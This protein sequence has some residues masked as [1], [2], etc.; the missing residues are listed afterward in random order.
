MLT[1]SWNCKGCDF[2]SSK[3]WQW[4]NPLQLAAVQETFKTDPKLTVP[5]F[6]TFTAPASRLPLS[7]GSSSDA[8]ATTRGR[9]KGSLASFIATNV[10][11]FYD[12][13]RVDAA[14]TNVELLV[15]SLVRKSTAPPESSAPFAFLF[16]NCYVRP[17]PD[18]VDFDDLFA[19]FDALR[20]Q[21]DCPVIIAGDFNAHL[22][23]P[24]AQRLPS[25][26]DVCF[27]D[28]V[29]RLESVG[30]SYAFY[31]SRE[32]LTIQCRCPRLQSLAIARCRVFYSGLFLNQCNFILACPN[33]VISRVKCLPIFSHVLW[34]MV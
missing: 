26:R 4:V 2:R 25:P 3:F 12:V 28:F 11:A 32:C 14:V 5:G 23:H 19:T 17:L 20:A 34:P 29:T 7:T 9:A 30:F 33:V 27:Y 10:A 15:L 24:A 31:S 16:V 22:P 21:F 8:T 1:G 6:Q 13:S 18:L